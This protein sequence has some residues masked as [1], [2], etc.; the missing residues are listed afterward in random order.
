MPSRWVDTGTGRSGAHQKK[1]KTSDPKHDLHEIRSDR[2]DSPGKP[3]IA[4]PGGRAREHDG[5]YPRRASHQNAESAETDR[6]H[7]R[8]PPSR[9]LG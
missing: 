3:H 4:A 7:Y 5:R 6:N 2:G 1:G 8:N 9:R